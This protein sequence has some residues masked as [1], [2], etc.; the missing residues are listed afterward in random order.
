M[1]FPADVKYT[2]EHEWVRVEGTIAT[3]GITAHAQSELGDVVY[4]DIPDETA[5]VSPGDTIGTIEAVKTVADIYSPLS[6]TISAVN[7]V[8]VN[9]D[10]V[11]HEPYSGGWLIKIEMTDPS[12]VDAL[13][14]VDAYKQLI[15][16]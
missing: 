5:S 2:K 7:A 9:P 16:Q 6:G 4:V 12:E 1:E 11:N 8:N 10:I 14:T 13:L 3:I 15:G